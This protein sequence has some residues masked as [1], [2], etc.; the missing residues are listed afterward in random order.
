MNNS[1]A[2]IAL[3]TAGPRTAVRGDRIRK[4]ANRNGY[5]VHKSRAR[6]PDFI[7]FGGAFH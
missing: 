2:A 7:G 3:A 5:A 6:N 1:S 4:L